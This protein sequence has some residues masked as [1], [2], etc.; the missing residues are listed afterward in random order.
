V[1]RENS[2]SRSRPPWRAWRRQGEGRNAVG[3]SERASVAR[4]S[5]ALARSITTA[6][7]VE[8]LFDELESVD[9]VEVAFLA[10]VDEDEGRAHGFAARGADEARWRRVSFDLNDDPGGVGIAG[11]ER[12]PYAVF[13]L[14]SGARVPDWL[15]EIEAKSAAFVPLLVDGRVTGVLVAATRT[16]PRF[17]GPRELEIFQR[18]ADETASVL[19]RRRSADALAAALARERLI[20][21]LGRKVRSELDLDKVLEV[22]VHETAEALGVTRCLIRLGEPGEPMPIAAEWRSDDAPAAADVSEHLPASNLAVRERRTV[23]IADVL[24]APELDDRSLGRRETLV[25]LGAGSALATPILVFDE[26]IGVFTVLRPAPGRWA[27]AEVALVEA[28]AGEVGLAVHA[29][30]LLRADNLRLGRQAALLKAAQVV[31]SDLRF[32]SVLRRLVE[33]VASLLEA[34]AADC[35]ILEPGQGLLSCRAVTGLPASEIGRRIPPAGTIGR[36]IA[37]G[38]PVVNRRFREHEEPPPSSNYADFEEVMVAPITWLGEIRGVLGICSRDRGHFDETDLEVV[39]AYARFASLAFHNAESF[40]ERERQA[41]I[42]QGFYR[43]AEVLGSPLSLSETVDAL[44][45]AAA[46]ALGGVSAFVLERRGDRLRHSG[47]YDLRPEVA[48]AL[49]EGIPDDESP[50][51]AASRE[52]RL[53]TSTRVADDDRFAESWRRVITEQAGAASLLAAPVATAGGQPGAVVVLFTAERSF[54]DEDLALARHLSR[55]ARGALERGE[56]YETERRA[57]RVS[58]RLAEIGATLVANLDPSVVLEDLVREA[59]RLVEAEAATIRLL[60]GEDLVVRAAGGVGGD[61]VHALV[62]KRRPIGAGLVGTVAQTREV[63]TVENAAEQ[64]E[65]RRGDPLLE[66]SMAACVAV[67]VSGHG[68]GLQGVLTVYASQPRVWR[69]EETQALAAL[70]VVASAALANA[71]LYQTVAEEKERSSAILLHI[72]D[73]IVAVDRNERIVLWNPTAEQ[74]TGVPAPEAL[75]RT[76]RDVLQRDLAGAEPQGGPGEP[77]TIT[78][79]GKD[80]FLSVAEAVMLDAA[81]NVAGRIFAFRDVSSERVL[82][83]MKSDFVATVSHELRTPLTSIYGFA[84]TLLR[85]DIDFSETERATFLGY[86][87]SESERLIEIVDDLLNVARLEAGTLGLSLRP[88]NVGELVAGVAEGTRAALGDY[89]RVVVEVDQPEG[90]LTADA[91]PE[92]LAQILQQLVDNAIKFS[93]EG[94]TITISGRRRA[95]SI[96]VR[97]SDEGI[98]IPHADQQR[99]F[100]KFYRAEGETGPSVPGTGLGLFLVRGLLTAMGGRISVESTEGRG[101]TFAFELPVSKR[102]SRGRQT[103]VKA[104]NP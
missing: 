86:I 29:A 84:E 70:G 71:R 43:I 74:I 102:A 92:K 88:T 68:G 72:A 49:R 41:Q 17:F 67:P 2:S 90:S 5:T 19:G 7:A 22:A 73:G 100:T 12:E 48:E 77:V 44:A 99:I 53:V 1:A 98:G 39:D 83:Q 20:G 47:S 101:S 60:D 55:A 26:I 50:L 97:V 75:G 6:E 30:R 28:V 14:G 27:E 10:L 4:L 87:A 15:E 40:E 45:E 63:G 3:D 95:D 21:R 31:T 80:V 61:A 54:S 13:D 8:H 69:E 42:Q 65:L 56:L 59:P 57:R 91:D 96:E 46:E 66:G 93:P 18:L 79:G 35:W 89:A 82:E 58:Q 37:E 33:E 23:A 32:Q 16:E 36:A 11:R 52:E 81:G 38:R 34:D 9:G 62:G 24:T 25:D 85:R 78:R 104:A 94:G 103:T 64:P 76:V 51:G